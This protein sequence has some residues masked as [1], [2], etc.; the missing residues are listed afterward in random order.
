MIL[1]IS[2]IGYAS[3]KAHFTVTF[4]FLLLCSG[5]LYAGTWAGVVSDA[6]GAMHLDASEK[7]QRCVL[8]SVKRGQKPVL[9]TPSE[10]IFQ[11][12]NPEKVMDYLGRRVV[13]TGDLRGEKIVIR[14]VE[15][16][17]AKQ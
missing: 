12:A 6:C 10:K 7:S 17:A 14:N 5:S 13:V 15:A 1:Q 9:V 2:P 11:I 4:S 3:R 8:M 16:A